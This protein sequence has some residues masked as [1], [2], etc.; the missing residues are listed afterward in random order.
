MS[1]YSFSS[2]NNRVVTA[3]AF[4]ILILISITFFFQAIHFDFVNWDDDL[5]VY[6][7]VT[8][9]SFDWDNIKT[10]FTKPFVALYVPV[11]LISY[12]LDYRFFGA[13][14][15]GFHLT[16]ILLH[17]ANTAIIF[18]IFVFIFEDCLLSFFA[19]LLFCIHPVQ[20]E[21]VVWISQ[22]K[23]LLFAFFL[24]LGFYVRIRVLGKGKHYDWLILSVICF[25]LSLFS[26]ATAIM[27]PFML[28]CYEYFYR[29]AGKREG[30]VVAL[31][32]YLV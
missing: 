21:T 19:A 28:I 8:I 18:L 14:A 12:A 23:N 9:R 13:D 16:N 2:A 6:N 30:L 1:P 5:Y 15:S 17:T 27:I 22:R 11:P 25:V 7:N 31:F 3:V 20:V 4:L 24:L 29:G 10:W 32:Y 26:K